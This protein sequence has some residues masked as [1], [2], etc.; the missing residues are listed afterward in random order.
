MNEK[1]LPVV[2]PVGG[3]LNVEESLR[4]IASI[5]WKGT[6]TS[7]LPEKA[8]LWANTAAKCGLIY[9]SIHSPFSGSEGCR[10]SELWEE[11]DLIPSE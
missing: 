3:G 6:F 9:Q 11:G 7:W 5:G 10:V 8:E 1:F 4:L 2:A